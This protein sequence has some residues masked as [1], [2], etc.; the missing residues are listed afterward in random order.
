[1]G[2]EPTSLAASNFKSDVYANSTTGAYLLIFV[3]YQVLTYKSSLS[4]PDV[5]LMGV[6]PTTHSF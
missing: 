5:P 2:L 3:Y 6:E 4:Y 1:M